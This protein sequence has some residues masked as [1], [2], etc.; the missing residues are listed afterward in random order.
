MR[1]KIVGWKIWDGKIEGEQI[2][3][4]KVYAEIQLAAGKG[5]AAKGFCTEEIKVPREVCEQIAH[6]ETPF[7]AE[8]ETTRTSNGKMSKEVVIGVKVDEAGK[9]SQAKPGVRPAVAA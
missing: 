9:V 1:V 2:S 6:L 7:M 4:S 5:G 3:S 8:L